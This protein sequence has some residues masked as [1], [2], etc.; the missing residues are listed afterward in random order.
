MAL[1]LVVSLLPWANSHFY[2]TKCAL[3]SSI[4]AKLTVPYLAIDIVFY[5]LPILLD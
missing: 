1:K 3:G 2:V 4:L 5:D